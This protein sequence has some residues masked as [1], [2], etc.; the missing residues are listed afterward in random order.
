MSLCT[1]FELQ[2]CSVHEIYTSLTDHKDFLKKLSSVK[3]LQKFYF[4]L[5]H[6]AAF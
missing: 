5:S 3:I 6:L 2:L 4:L 1:E